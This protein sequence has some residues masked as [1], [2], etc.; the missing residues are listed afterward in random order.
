MRW[1]C[2]QAPLQFMFQ[3]KRKDE[4]LS[5]LLM[6]PAWTHACFF[7]SSQFIVSIQPGKSWELQPAKRKTRM[8]KN[9]T[10]CPHNPFERC[11]EFERGHEEWHTLD[12]PL[13]TWGSELTKKALFDSV[14]AILMT[15]SSSLSGKGKRKRWD[16]GKHFP[17]GL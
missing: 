10:Y 8:D 12:D 16:E 17:A 7:R 11:F 1:V 13:L 6:W 14:A 15:S 5:K 2:E 4:Q 9:E 3:N